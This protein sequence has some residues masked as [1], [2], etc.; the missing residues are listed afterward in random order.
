[1]RR[2]NA[3]LL[4]LPALLAL[5][6]PAAADVT[7]FHRDARFFGETVG[8]ETTAGGTFTVPLSEQL[9]VNFSTGGGTPTTFDA[10]ATTQGAPFRLGASNYVSAAANTALSFNIAPND[11]TNIVSLVQSGITDNSVTITGGSGTAYLLP[12]FRI[13]GSFDDSHASAFASVSMCAGVNSCNPMN[14][15]TSLTSTVVD[16]LFTPDIGLSTD[17]IFDT[18]FTLFFFMSA[19]IASSS[20][21]NLAPGALGADFAGG[22]ELV[23]FSVVDANGDPL[24]GA[25]IHSD[26]LDLLTVPEPAP[27]ALI[28][29]GL[30][31]LILRRHGATRT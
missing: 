10:L 12:T 27:L 2:I 22:L 29:L 9:P 1:M 18:P 3:C 24:P 21:G 23:G 5:A 8:R 28:A 30:S 11:P 14:V 19:G 4:G 16:A 17:F 15:A 31:A 13:T 7:Y 6:A 26:F 20:I 25:V